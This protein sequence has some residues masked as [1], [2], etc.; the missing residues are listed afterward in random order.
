MV[1]R[2]HAH[3]A[4]PTS[5][6]G[7]LAVATVALVGALAAAEAWARHADGDL[8]FPRDGRRYATRPGTHGTNSLGLHERELPRDPAPGVRRIVVLGDSMTWGTAGA[9]DTWTRAAEAALGPPWE[10]VNLSHY[11]YDADQALASLEALGWGYR[12]E[13]VVYAAYVNDLVPTEL[14]TVGDPP[15]P[16]WIGPR[17]NPLRA[18]S[19]LARR[20]EGAVRARGFVEREDA[21]AW[22]AA[23]A[24][25]RDACA[26]RGVPLQGLG[27]VPHVLAEPDPARC[28]AAA[29]AP[30]RCA[31]ALDRHARQAAIAGEL[32][33]AWFSTLPAL[34][35]GPERSWFDAGSA[36]WEHPSPAGHRLL[37]GEI[38][39][40]L[41]STWTTGAAPEAR[42]EAEPT[43]AEPA[44]GGGEVR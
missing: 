21:D 25:M 3:L 5:R 19:S 31:E 9:D 8:V 2:S 12:P 39:A 40:L 29:G 34:R 28:D 7:R 22:A 41:G 14:I 44:I 35:A 36:D 20:V 15:M 30:G 37:G 4:A 23:L 16:A 43:G 27:L 10:L 38:A 33:V 26:A 13:L 24:A 18:W 32:G 17:G 11:G 6:I 1:R 42:P